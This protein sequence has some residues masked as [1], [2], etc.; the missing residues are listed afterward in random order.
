MRLVLILFCIFNLIAA[1]L[2]YNDPDALFWIILYLI[3]FTLTVVYLRQRHLKTVNIIA[4]I[5]YLI[6]FF[7][8]FPDLTDWAKMGF[9]SIVGS[10]EAATPYIERVREAGGVLIVCVNL[11]LLLRPVRR[12]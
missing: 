5:V 10:M 1:V 7:T 4:L 2:Q 3:P 11:V 9:S 12:S 6:Y 8:F